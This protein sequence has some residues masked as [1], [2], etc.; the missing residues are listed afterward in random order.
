MTPEEHK[1]LLG[2]LHLIYGAFH[3]LLAFVLV[4][5]FGIP[6]AVIVGNSPGGDGAPLAFVIV[7]LLLGLLFSIVFMVPPLVAGYGLL[8]HKPWGRTASLVAAVVEVLNVPHGTAL[9][10]YNFWLLFG[11]GARAGGGSDLFG[12]NTRP[13]LG[14]TTARPAYGAFGREREREYAPPPQPPNWRGD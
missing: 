3:G 11:Q 9:A 5:A 8:K 2:I 7:A 1:R 6:A 10:I 13:A 12:A 4:I 14:E